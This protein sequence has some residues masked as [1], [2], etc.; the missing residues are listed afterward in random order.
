MKDV[1]EFEGLY[2]VTKEGKVW[3]YPKQWAKR[4]H[5]GQWLKTFDTNGYRAIY[6]KRDGKNHRFLVHRLVAITYLPI[7]TLIINHINGIRTDNR[8]SNIE[9]VTPREN[10][11]HARS[12][13]KVGNARGEKHPGSKLTENNVIK[14]REL[15]GLGEFSH[16]EIAA[17]YHLN[18]ATITRI[19]NR[20]SWTHI[21][22]A[23]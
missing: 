4:S 21:Q 14:I 19:V 10:N 6:L 22:K 12:V 5:Q 2:A 15:A 7:P 8:L 13:L 17:T 9:W 18:P 20:Q 3:S 11:Y 1:P 23:A 16:R